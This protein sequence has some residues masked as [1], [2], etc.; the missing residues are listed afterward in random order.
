MKKLRAEGGAAHLLM[1][2]AEA[3]R[4]GLRSPRRCTLTSQRGK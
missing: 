1:S 3:V 2:D 4:R